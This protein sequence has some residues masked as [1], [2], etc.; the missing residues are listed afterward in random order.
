MKTHFKRDARRTL[1]GRKRRDVVE[2]VDPEDVDCKSCRRA[3]G[4]NKK[5]RRRA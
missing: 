5:R 4:A 2:A 3:F 1:C